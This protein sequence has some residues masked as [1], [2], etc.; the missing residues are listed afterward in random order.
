VTDRNSK[1]Q[2]AL[3]D[4]LIA[5]A[6][7]EVERYLV[8]QIEAQE[9]VDRLIRLLDGPRQREVQRRALEALAKG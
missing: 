9:V 5:A 8:K 7:A 6:Q 3:R 4:A 2:F 1:P